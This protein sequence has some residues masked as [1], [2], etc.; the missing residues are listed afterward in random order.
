MADNFYYN[1]ATIKSDN[2]LKT[3]A[4]E[5]SMSAGEYNWDLLFPES[6]DNIVDTI[7]LH[8]I[9]TD[10]T[11][12]ENLKNYDRYLKIFKP[13]PKSLDANEEKLLKKYNYQGN[14]TNYEISYITKYFAGQN[15][16]TTPVNEVTF[17][18]S[19]YNSVKG[20]STSLTDADM[21]LGNS[22]DQSIMDSIKYVK[23]FLDVNELYLYAKELNG[24]DSLTTEEQNALNGYKEARV[25]T[26][27]DINKYN[28]VKDN[29]GLTD[30]IAKLVV[31]EY[32]SMASSLTSSIG[33]KDS[34]GNAIPDTTVLANYR[35]G[36]AITQEEM[37]QIA[38]ILAGV[39]VHNT[40]MWQIGDKI[41]EDTKRD[42]IEDHSSI[43]ARFSWYKSIHTNLQEYTGCDYWITLNKDS[44]NL[45][46]RGDPSVDIYPYKNWLVSYAYVGR[47]LPIDE[48]SD[49]DYERNWAMT[50]SSDVSPTLVTDT[51]SE[52][53]GAENETYGFKTATGV[54]DIT[55]LATT[56]G[57]P[58]QSH[59]PAFYTTNPTMDKV[60]MDGSR[61]NKKKHQYSEI[62]VVHGFDME[63]GKMQNILIGDGSSIYD[64][65]KL[66]YLKKD[67]DPEMYIKFKISAPY[68]FVNNSPNVD[69]TLALRVTFENITSGNENPG[70]T[71]TSTTVPPTTTTT[72]GA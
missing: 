52:H 36:R 50:V 12:T 58:Y 72:T 2:L 34:D 41:D 6:V 63:R 18:K 64:G 42:F 32:Y 71:T 16:S 22:T 26:Q 69:Y 39:N 62:T 37:N 43:P 20:H 65:D 59:L 46:V 49:P 67:Q 55:M 28:E 61:W 17:L 33:A 23:R 45:V 47:I 31:L 1:T 51:S 57:V 7:M 10:N 56:V 8:T 68:N 27:D 14:F 38:A 3:L 11:D 13:Q 5:V 60:N 35:S 19:W 24:S 44:L 70:T 29:R 4:K 48:E 25:V 54:T 66:V 40:L 15:F 9:V 21:E 53:F 30:D